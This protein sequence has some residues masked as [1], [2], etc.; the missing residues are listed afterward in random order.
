MIYDIHVRVPEQSIWMFV[1][2]VASAEEAMAAMVAARDVGA[3]VRIGRRL[4][5]SVVADDVR[6]M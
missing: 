4:T 2:H 5:T 1:Q 6:C 3:V